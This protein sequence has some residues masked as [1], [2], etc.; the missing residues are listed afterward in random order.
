MHSHLSNV[1]K[2]VHVLE[3]RSRQKNAL[4]TWIN[5]QRALCAEWKSRPAKLRIEAAQSELQSMNDLLTNVGDRRN[6]AEI[7]LIIRP[8]GQDA[9]IEESLTKLESELIDAI[10]SKQA[11]QDLIQKIDSLNA[12]TT[13]FEAEGRNR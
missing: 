4:I 13:E 9:D 3:D 12:I 8:D 5:Q 6:E 11:A 10:A 7:E 2:A 1:V